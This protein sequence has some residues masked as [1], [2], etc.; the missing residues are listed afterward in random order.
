MRGEEEG[1]YGP[2][3]AN[4]N[5]AIT[6]VSSMDSIQPASMHD[7]LLQVPVPPTRQCTTL[8][9]AVMI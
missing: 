4:T 3:V 1:G 2:L 5:T 9:T 6:I 8:R 7:I